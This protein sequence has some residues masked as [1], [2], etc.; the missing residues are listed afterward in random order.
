MIHCT[1]LLQHNSSPRQRHRA[2]HRVQS[3]RCHL[4]SMQ[5]CC[6]SMHPS[7]VLALCCDVGAPE[8]ASKQASLIHSFQSHGGTQSAIE[9]FDWVRSSCPHALAGDWQC[10]SQHSSAWLCTAGKRC[11]RCQSLKLHQQE[12][13]LERAHLSISH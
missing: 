13:F 4:P 7:M 3:C 1:L 5:A 2:G 12:H 10:W 8:Q 9:Q 6:E 11:T